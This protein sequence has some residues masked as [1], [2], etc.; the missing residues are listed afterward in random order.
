MVSR[1]TLWAALMFRLLVL[2][3]PFAMSAPSP[4]PVDSGVYALIGDNGEISPRNHGVVGNAGFSTI[5]Y[6]GRPAPA[7]GRIAITVVPT[8]R[9][10]STSRK[11]LDAPTR[12]G[13]RPA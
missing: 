12:N 2:Y 10:V 8:T 13:H 5:Y 6:D 9:S 7:S 11:V 3:S 1:A 4:V